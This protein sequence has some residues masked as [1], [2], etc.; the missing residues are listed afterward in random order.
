MA[1]R[2]SG[3]LDVAYVP[4]QRSAPDEGWS[5]RVA[6]VG[7]HGCLSSAE[8]VVVCC[9]L[10]TAECF[11]SDGCTALDLV[12]LERSIRSQ[13]GRCGYCTPYSQMLCSV[14]YVTGHTSVPMPVLGVSSCSGVA[15]EHFLH[16]ACASVGGSVC[17]MGAPRV[18]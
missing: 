8:G 14:P 16:C 12:E 13:A 6:K 1:S 15:L 2:V 18:V 4:T 10:D 7:E 5:C 9:G 11:S 3:G 17:D